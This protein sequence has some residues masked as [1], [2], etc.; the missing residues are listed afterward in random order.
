[1]SREE[2]IAEMIKILENQP[3]WLLEMIRKTIILVT[4]ED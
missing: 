2:H 1:M 3:L 4:K